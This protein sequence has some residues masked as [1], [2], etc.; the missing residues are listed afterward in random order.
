MTARELG[1][2]TLADA[3]DLLILE[4]EKDRQSRDRGRI[5]SVA[6]ALPRGA[7]LP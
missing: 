7:L 1:R 5:T 4:A 6:E 2:L 3:L